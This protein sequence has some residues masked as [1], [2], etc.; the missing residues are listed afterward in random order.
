V[1]WCAASVFCFIS[2]AVVPLQLSARPRATALRVSAPA[3]GHRQL[4]RTL[5]ECDTA[6]I[7][8]AE[9]SLGIL[10]E[11]NHLT[12]TAGQHH[13]PNGVLLSER[14]G[15]RVEF[16]HADS[17][18]FFFCD[19]LNRA[20]QVVRVVTGIV[21]KRFSKLPLSLC[22]LGG[23]SGDPL[24]SA[25]IRRNRLLQLLGVIGLE[26]LRSQVSW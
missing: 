17:E 3:P 8:R 12:I 4:F 11:A 1:S 2:D 18:G 6:V 25:L 24:L 13:D 20:Q 15:D 7:Q 26:I 23:F 21:S 16:A 5:C 19:D 14:R 10:Y 9:R 22:P